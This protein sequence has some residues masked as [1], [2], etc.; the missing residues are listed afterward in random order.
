MPF[1]VYVIITDVTQVLKQFRTLK[2][3][4]ICA[5]E[6]E[7]DSFSYFSQNLTILIN[8]KAMEMEKYIMYTFI[9]VTFQKQTPHLFFKTQWIKLK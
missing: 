4:L 8:E 3:F 7:K 1:I 2:K 5:T 9:N 6:F